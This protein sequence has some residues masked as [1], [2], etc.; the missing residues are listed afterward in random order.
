VARG[1][2]YDLRAAPQKDRINWHDN[3]LDVLAH[4]LSKGCLYFA[5]GSGENCVYF[6]PHACGYCLRT[7]DHPI[8]CGIGPTDEQ[9][10][11]AGAGKQLV[12]ETELL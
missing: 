1:K 11:S 3:S 4:E 5:I 8:E 10:K 2:R 12:E 6:P 7:L 9:D